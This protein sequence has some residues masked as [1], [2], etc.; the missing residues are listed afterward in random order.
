[1]FDVDYRI[2]DL[3]GEHYYF[4]EASLALARTLHR[5]KE[6]MDLWHP[7]ECIGE[8]GSVIGPA[9]IAVASAAARKTYAPGPN[10]LIHAANDA[11]ERIAIVARG[12]AR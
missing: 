1:M 9:M 8:A 2:A 4:K 5:R 11:G 3:S 10:V 6:D 12:E 7:A